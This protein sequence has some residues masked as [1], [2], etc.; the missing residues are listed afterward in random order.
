MPEITVTG[1]LGPYCGDLVYTVKY[2]IPLL[3]I[4]GISDP[5]AYLNEV[6]TIN[7]IDVDLI[8]E[9]RPY[10]VTVSF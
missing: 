7:T 8:D 4:N 2:G 9:T 5:V 10:E 6:F 1:G 3:P